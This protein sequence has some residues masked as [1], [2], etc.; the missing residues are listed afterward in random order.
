LLPYDVADRVFDDLR[1]FRSLLGAM[2]PSDMD[3]AFVVY[4]DSLSKI[5]QTDADSD[6]F[7]TNCVNFS[8]ILTNFLHLFAYVEFLLYLCARK[9]FFEL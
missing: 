5:R 4:M 7:H 2:H 9:G 1:E 3:L 6:V 8:T